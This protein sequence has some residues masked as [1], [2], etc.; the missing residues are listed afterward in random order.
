[1]YLFFE[2][3][4]AKLSIIDGILSMNAKSNLLL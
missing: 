2:F 1:M 4:Q 3:I